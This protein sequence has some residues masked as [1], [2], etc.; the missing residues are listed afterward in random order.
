MRARL[1]LALAA[2]PFVVVA[3]I[4][5]RVDR[6]SRR[7]AATASARA[8]VMLGARVLPSGHAAPALQYRA[9]KAAQLYLSGRAPLIVFSGGSSGK[10]PSEASIARDLAV[11]AGVPPTACLL[12]DQ[13][14]STA[15]NAALTAPLL[16]ARGIDEVLLVSDGYHL[17]RAQAQFQALGIRAH[18][19]PSGRRLGTTDWLSQTVREALAL[20]RRPWLLWA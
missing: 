19:V 9:E 17:L 4:A 11:A 2:L 20:L 15:Q 12:E 6:A 18:P 5:W 3:A 7:P 16:K 8:V 14:H 10:L 13:S 1:L